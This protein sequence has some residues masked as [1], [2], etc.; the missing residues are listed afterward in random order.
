MGNLE[1]NKTKAND[2]TSQSARGSYSSSPLTIQED[3]YPI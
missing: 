2:S 3:F 1:K